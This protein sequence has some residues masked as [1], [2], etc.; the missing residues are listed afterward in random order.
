M[1]TNVDLGVFADASLAYGEEE[2]AVWVETCTLEDQRRMCIAAEW[3][4]NLLMRAGR[5][6][7]TQAFAGA[8][9][10]IKEGTARPLARKRAKR[11]QDADFPGAHRSLPRDMLWNNWVYDDVVTEQFKT[12]WQEEI[13]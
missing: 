9:A 10:F 5:S 8:A 7:M 2:I 11:G 13:R 6:V 3:L 4:S 1:P 12:F